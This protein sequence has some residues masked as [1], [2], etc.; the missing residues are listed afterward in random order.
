MMKG[1]ILCVEENS[2]LNF[3]IKTVL[4]KEFHV[5]CVSGAFEAYNYLNVSKDTD[6]VILSIESTDDEKL[7]LYHQMKTSATQQDIPI[8][9]LSSLEEEWIEHFCRQNNVAGFFS[10]P[11]DPLALLNL[12]NALPLKTEEHL[13]III[14]QSKTLHLN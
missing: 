1:N 5:H 7:A 14:Q 10:K 3:L 4:G 9:V 12:I 8:V 2:S 6:C 13:K 11:F